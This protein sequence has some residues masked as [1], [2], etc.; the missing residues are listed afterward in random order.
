[1]IA[2][3]YTT[4]EHFLLI[5]ESGELRP[6]DIL[7]RPPEKPVLW[8]S[9]NQ[10]WEATAC[11]G[12]VDGGQRRT[13]T[14]EETMQMCQG[15]VRFGVRLDRLHPWKKLQRKARM[16]ERTIIM[17][18]REGRRQGADPKDWYGRTTAVPIDRCASIQVMDESREWVE[19]T[20]RP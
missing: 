8:F 12:L 14:M 17:L 11:K 13:L 1:M 5:V 3:H 6:T 18:E 9:I 2:W 16:S 4:G 7:V 15:L 10:R 20:K 19:V